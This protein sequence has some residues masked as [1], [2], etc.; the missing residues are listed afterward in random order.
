MDGTS[1]YTGS[2]KAGEYLFFTFWGWVKGTLM[3][4]EASTA[5]GRM[6]KKGWAA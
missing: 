1:A 4:T 5:I 6:R 2:T 3:L